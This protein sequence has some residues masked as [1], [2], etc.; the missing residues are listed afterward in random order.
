MDSGFRRNDEKLPVR[1]ESPGYQCLLCV[2]TGFNSSAVDTRP[3]GEKAWCRFYRSRSLVRFFV[4]EQ[5]VAE[6][7]EPDPNSRK[8]DK[9][10][11]VECLVEQGNAA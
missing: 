8:P 2:Y 1:N 6:N 10:I 3:D 11:D 4:G 5:A 7:G 9:L